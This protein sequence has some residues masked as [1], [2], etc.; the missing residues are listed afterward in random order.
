VTLTFLIENIT[1]KARI[2]ENNK[3]L[4]SSALY[5]NKLKD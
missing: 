1:D 4:N 5:D 2:K 3:A